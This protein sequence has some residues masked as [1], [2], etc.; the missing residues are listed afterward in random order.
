[1]KPPIRN[2]TMLNR[3]LSFVR[4]R[5]RSVYH[6]DLSGGAMNRPV[7]IFVVLAVLVVALLGAMTAAAAT[8]CEKLAGLSLQNAK[9]DSAQTVPAGTFTQPGRGAGARGEANVFATL[10]ASGRLTP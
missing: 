9:I 5:R 10:P 4:D 1:M 3:N 2:N 7:S 6:W 8:P